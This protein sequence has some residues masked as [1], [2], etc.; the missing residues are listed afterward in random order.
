MTPEAIL[1]FWFQE[2]ANRWWKPDPV[3]DEQIRVQFQ[4]TYDLAAAGLL[5]DWVKQGP[6]SNLAYIILLDQFSR[7]LYRNQANCYAQD[8]KA[9]YA[10]QY[11]ISQCFDRSLS[12]IERSMYYMPLMH[13]EDLT[14]QQQSVKCFEQLLLEADKS[15]HS[16]M[17]GA[18]DFAIRHCDVVA[19]FGRFPH[20]NAVLGRKSIP[21]EVKFLASPDAPF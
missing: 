2:P 8:A 1:K 4:R 14:A 11:G 7:N 21:E 10:C 19:R 16:S 6:R 12:L 15:E 9:V 3:F 17:E 5:E 18:L 20:R 13:A